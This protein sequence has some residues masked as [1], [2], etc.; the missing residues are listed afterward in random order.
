MRNALD[1]PRTA[2][3]PGQIIAHRHM[4]GFSKARQPV[5]HSGK[6][7]STTNVTFLKMKYFSQAEKNGVLEANH[8]AHSNPES[9]L[10]GVN[11]RREPSL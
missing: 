5:L 11:S 3:D 7:A 6:F 4:S 1:S 8:P 2:R 10:L 9:E